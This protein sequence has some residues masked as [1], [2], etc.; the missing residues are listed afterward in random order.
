MKTTILKKALPILF[1]VLVA[2]F[3]VIYLNSID[4]S[5]FKNI[6]PDLNFL[7]A[8]GIL[9]LAGR[10][11]AV[12][13]WLIILETLGAKN[14]NKHKTQLIYVFAKAW[15]GRYIPGTAPWILGKIYF[16]GQL[17]INKSKLAVSS[18]LESGLQIVATTA[19][20]F[21]LLLFSHRFGAV[22]QQYKILMII[23]LAG[24]VIAVLPPVFNSL[25]SFGYKLISKKILAT[26]H[27]A[28][29]RTIVLGT[30]AYAVSALLMGL[31]TFFV[32]KAIYPGLNYQYLLFVVGADNLSG[33]AGMLAIFVPSGIG[34]RDGIFLAL[35]SIIMPTETAFVITVATR[36]L[37][38]ILD[39]L[40]F[41]LA[42]LTKQ[43]FDH[44]KIGGEN[45]I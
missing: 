40:F 11:W 8:A 6:H 29:G 10:Y 3:L 34:V 32:A 28:S 15:M 31:S 21:V 42:G 26:E 23:V 2:A 27:L 14:L 43:V 25:M 22:D 41:G 13:D 44:Y 35:L 18:L 20:A 30:A 1:Y 16:A 5:K 4:F 19:V 33:V 12:V 17:G 7:I 36:L 24:L 37:H 9:G 39:V 45:I 38:V